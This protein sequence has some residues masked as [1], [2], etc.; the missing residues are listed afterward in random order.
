MLS[1]SLSLSLSLCQRGSSATG[2]VRFVHLCVCVTCHAERNQLH[3]LPGAGRSSINRAVGYDSLRFY[4]QN[5]LRACARS[6]SLSAPVRHTAWITLGF[7][8]RLRVTHIDYEQ[9]SA[10]APFHTPVL[11]DGTNCQNTHPCW[12]L[13]PKTTGYS[14]AALLSSAFNIICLYMCGRLS[15]LS[16]LLGAL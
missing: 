1:L 14:R 10:N 7:F 3:R 8:D 6:C 9:S 15:Q 16:W 4:R 13:T 5:A 2:P 11:R 12:K